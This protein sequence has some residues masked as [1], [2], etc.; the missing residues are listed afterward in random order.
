MSGDST[1][2]VSTSRH[3][4]SSDS[5]TAKHSQAELESAGDTIS[6]QCLITK[7]LDGA[8]GTTQLKIRVENPAEFLLDESSEE[9]VKR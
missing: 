5:V 2:S 7:V 4:K 3:N 9:S 8:T 1:T 6:E